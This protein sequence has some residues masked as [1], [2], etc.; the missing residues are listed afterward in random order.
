MKKT[1]CIILMAVMLIFFTAC[2]QTNEKVQ[3]AENMKQASYVNITAKQAKEIMD[4]E[5][6]YIILDV[7]TEEEFEEG[8]IPGAIL[9]PD[10][11]IK[12]RAEEILTDK[13]QQLLVYCRSGRR[14]KLAS[15]ALLDLGYTNIKE[16]GGII[17]WPYEVEKQSD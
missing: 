6:G 14:S 17:D 2:G 1:A 10:Y 15:E 3:E 9:I 4:T 8:H 11:E 12:T 5:S 13:N 16:F 7:R